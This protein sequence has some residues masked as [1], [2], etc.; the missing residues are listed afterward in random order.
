MVENADYPTF[1]KNVGGKEPS[2]KPTKIGKWTFGTKMVR[3]V[4]VS[5]MHGDVLN[6][7][8]GK[9]DLSE[10]KRGVDIHRN[11][12]NEDIP[13]DTHHDVLTID[14]HFEPESFDTVIF[15]PPFNARLSEKL[16]EGMHA[17]DYIAARDAVAPLL[18]R[19]GVHIELGWNSWGQA[20][21]D[22]W[23]RV[24]AHHYRQPF[25]GDVWLVVDRKVN[26]RRLTDQ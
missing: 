7:C 12:L 23:E 11:D 5:H 15:D 17:N 19:G 14:E 4:I 9:T 13:A 1:R 10:Y 3:D 21:R 2:G 18:K 24:E 8:A 22:G 25:K 26:Q 20:G 6:A 16:Y